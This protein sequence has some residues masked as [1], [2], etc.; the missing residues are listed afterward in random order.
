MPAPR[1]AAAVVLAALAVTL[2]GLQ[3]CRGPA[4]PGQPR[5]AG[6]APSDVSPGPTLAAPAQPASGPPPLAGDE[7]GLLTPGASEGVARL[8]AARVLRLFCRLVDMRRLPQAMA[9]L[10]PGAWSRRELRALAGLRFVSARVYGTPDA[11][12]LV[13]LTRVDVRLRAPSP[14]PD[15]AATL[16]F[17]LG[18]VGTTTGGGWLI[19]AV[20]T[21]P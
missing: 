8:E 2:V 4:Q 14:L 7:S 17:T 11:R 15:G 13:M 5:P 10:A 20:S 1:T 6:P 16:F 19:T 18:R 3:A 21:S 9:L 12:S